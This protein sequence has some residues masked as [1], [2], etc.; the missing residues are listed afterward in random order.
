MAEDEGLADDQIEYI[1]KKLNAGSSETTEIFLKNDY[2]YR[3]K[4][5]RYRIKKKDY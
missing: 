3:I 4:K 5:N 1:R 2:R